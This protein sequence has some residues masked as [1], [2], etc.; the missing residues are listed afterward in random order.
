[1]SGTNNDTSNDMHKA[2]RYPI[3]AQFQE[4]AYI[5]N[6]QYQALYQQSVTDPEGFWAQQ[7]QRIDWI[8]PFSQVKDVSFAKDDLHI[9]WFEDGTLNASVNC[10]DRH[11]AQRGDVPAIIWEADQ[12]ACP[13]V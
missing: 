13:G 9:R 11:L 4:R 8:K 5:N 10:I 2:Q 6:E 1:M 3:A 7:A 12:E